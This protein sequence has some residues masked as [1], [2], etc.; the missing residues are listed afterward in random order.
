MI[1][2]YAPKNEIAPRQGD[3]LERLYRDYEPLVRKVARRATDSEDDADDVVQEVFLA[4]PNVLGRYQEQGRFDAWLSRLTMRTALMRRRAHLRAERRVDDTASQQAPPHD[5]AILARLALA[6]AL[7][8]LPE[9][10]RAVVRLREIEG[11]SHDE[12]AERLGISRNASEVRLHRAMKQL[13]ELL[14]DSR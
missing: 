4:L 5:A 14:S 13:R 7:A 8:E 11:L 2:G 1:E 12:I 6:E 10:A 9:H 3:E